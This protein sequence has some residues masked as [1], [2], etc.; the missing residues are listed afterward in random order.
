MH[1]VKGVGFRVWVVGCRV[2][3]NLGGRLELDTVRAP[4]PFA[5][6]ASCV[7]PNR[8]KNVKCPSIA[9]T[10]LSSLRFVGVVFEG[11]G[12]KV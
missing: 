6:S 8:P 10:V 9:V 2:K 3:G 1:R 12:C 4:P 11:G 7:P 5:A